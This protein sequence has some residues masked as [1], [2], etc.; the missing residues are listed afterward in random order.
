MPM[1]SMP[2]VGLST[3]QTGSAVHVPD[4]EILQSPLHN[5]ETRIV[6]ANMHEYLFE[7]CEAL[8]IDDGKQVCMRRFATIG[9][10][11]AYITSD[12]I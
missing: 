2:E 11:V 9:V 3:A 5:A 12:A 1:L 10:D 4:S 7:P 6:S 8:V